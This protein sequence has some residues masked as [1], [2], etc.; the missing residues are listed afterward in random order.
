MKTY[1]VCDT[2]GFRWIGSFEDVP[3]K[4]S[5]GNFSGDSGY[6]IADKHLLRELTEFP[7]PGEFREVVRFSLL[8]LEI[9][10]APEPLKVWACCDMDGYR[11][12]RQDQEGDVV[13]FYGLKWWDGDLPVSGKILDDIPDWPA[14]GERRELKCVPKVV[15]EWADGGAK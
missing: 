3:V 6:V 4:K 9:E 1:A 2:D 14:P 10:Y 7:A 8:P 12:M 5:N 11:E 15:V 13:R